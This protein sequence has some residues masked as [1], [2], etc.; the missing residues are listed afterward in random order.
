MGRGAAALVLRVGSIVAV[1]FRFVSYQDHGC[2]VFIFISYS[3]NVCVDICEHKYRVG[4]GAAVLRAAGVDCFSWGVCIFNFI[5]ILILILIPILIFI[6]IFIFMQYSAL[7][8]CA[9]A[10]RVGRGA[11][12]L[13]AGGVKSC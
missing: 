13:H 5:L 12:T 7:C 3:N 10:S 4:C 8:L 2:V 11:A 1:A 9:S 6:F